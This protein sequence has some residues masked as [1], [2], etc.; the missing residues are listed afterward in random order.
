VPGAAAVAMHPVLPFAFR[1]AGFVIFGLA[2]LRVSVACWRN[3]AEQ[4][5]TA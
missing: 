5:A 3:A 4:P 2:C 1:L